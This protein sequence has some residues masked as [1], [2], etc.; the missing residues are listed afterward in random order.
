VTD[1]AAVT[2]DAKLRLL[3][4]HYESRVGHIGGNLSCLDILVTLFH[5]VM[6]T[7]DRFVLSKGHSAGALYV[8]LWTKGLLT[9]ADLEQFHR[10][11]TLLSGHPAARGLPGVLFGTGSLGHGLALA[12]G[13][14]L[15]NVLRGRP[16]RVYCL[17][18]DGECQEGATWEALIFGAHRNLPVT[19]IV[20]MN[21]LQGFGTTREI[22]GMQDLEA[23]LSAFCANVRIVDGHSQSEIAAA[24]SGAGGFQIVV[25]ATHK[26]SGVSFMEDRMEWHYL[27]L[28]KELY[29][30]AV[31][32]LSGG[33]AVN[34]AEARA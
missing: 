15:G 6:G 20:D 34:Y 25:A 11:G 12:N 18:S 31:G 29:E 27:P 19:A 16:G 33:L 17:L 9:D 28:S 4:M 26:G 14:A 24:C 10:D 5:D 7:T 3:R 13:L 1:L 30:Q 2:R 22:A 32:E 23:R 21:G 8:T